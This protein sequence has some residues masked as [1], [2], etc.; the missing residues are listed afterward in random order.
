MH[1]IDGQPVA[2]ATDLVGF[3]DCE[4]LT[5]LE[6]AALARLVT[7]PDREDPEL[8]MIARRGTEHEQKYLAWLRDDEGRTV[9]EISTKVDRDE[10]QGSMLRRAAQET[11]DALRRGD[12]VI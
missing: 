9:A 10:T 5:N 2:S 7:R 12:D 11:I 3:L 8:D 4:H 6:R 1:L